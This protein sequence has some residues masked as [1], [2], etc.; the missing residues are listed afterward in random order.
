MVTIE[1]II[2]SYFERVKINFEYTQY[3]YHLLLNEQFRVIGIS[4]GS[5]SG[6]TTLAENLVKLLGE[7][8]SVRIVVDGYLQYTRGQMK[9]LG[10]TGYDLE[11][12]DM[13]RF[14]KDLADLKENRVVEKPIFD[15]STA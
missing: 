4:G 2:E 3:L 7:D 1:E 6:K 10:L 5:G 8:S 15:E 9:N 13:T 12:R 11:S 14:L